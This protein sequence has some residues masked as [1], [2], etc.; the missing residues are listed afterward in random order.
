MNAQIRNRIKGALLGLSL[1]VGIGVSTSGTAQA[2]WQ[3]DQWRRERAAQ[4]EQIRRNASWNASKF[5]DIAPTGMMGVLGM[6]IG[7]TTTVDL[8]TFNRLP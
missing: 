1:L 7:A 5:V 3:N 4:R 8:M 6:M 2:Q